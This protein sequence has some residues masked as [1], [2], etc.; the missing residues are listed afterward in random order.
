MRLSN[1]LIT[2]TD[3]NKR[4]FS[5]NKTTILS[6]YTVL[7]WEAK[8]TMN[9]GDESE[10]AARGQEVGK[11]EVEGDISTSR[12]LTAASWL[13]LSLRSRGHHTKLDTV[14]LPRWIIKTFLDL[15]ID[16]LS[17]SNESLHLRSH[18]SVRSE[19]SLLT[20]STFAADLAEVSKKINPFSWAKI[21][22][23]LVLTALRCSKSDLL[24]ISMM[25]MFGFPFC[26]AS[27]NHRPRWLNDSRRVMSYTRSAPAASR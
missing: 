7:H 23:S 27:S 26:L 1:C 20:V 9:F 8:R 5:A 13:L 18:S 16:I 12:R 4:V 10:S 21:S 25:V 22:P 6:H 24:P 14:S 17:C 19:S 3:V 11:R 2:F 15:F